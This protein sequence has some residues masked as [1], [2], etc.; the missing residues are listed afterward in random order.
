MNRQAVQK[1]CG[2]VTTGLAY[3]SACQ[4]K[5]K[6]GGRV[7][8]ETECV[9]GQVCGE[10]EDGVVRCCWWRHVALDHEGLWGLVF[11]YLNLQ[12]QGFPGKEPAYQCRRCGL[13]HWVRKIPWGRKWQPTPVSCLENSMDRGAWQ[14]TV[15]GIAKSQT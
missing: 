3:R 13:H 8:K 7:E 4:I 9:K 6:W 15:H 11:F 2:E 14:A 12:L 5:P 10:G 1:G